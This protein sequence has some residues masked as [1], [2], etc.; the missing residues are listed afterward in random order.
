[1]NTH[2]AC[3]K[4]VHTLLY[5]HYCTYITVH[6]LLYIHYGDFLDLAQHMHMY[7]NQWQELWQNFSGR[8]GY[9]CGT[10]LPDKSSHSV[11]TRFALHFYELH[12]TG[13]AHNHDTLCATLERCTSHMTE[14]KESNAKSQWPTMM[15]SLREFC[16]QTLALIQMH[17]NQYTMHYMTPL[18][19]QV[20]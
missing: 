17:S 15:D 16:R 2:Y 9:Y 19:K 8:Q 18:I 3:K 5:I 14:D 1:M 11:L 13:S 12:Y 20:G 10:A 7:L 4:P 6:T